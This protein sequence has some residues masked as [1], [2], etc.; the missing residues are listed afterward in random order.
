M[1]SD[2]VTEQIVTVFAPAYK[3][4]CVA[5]FDLSLANTITY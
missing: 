1:P 2:K 4:L 3:H 5:G